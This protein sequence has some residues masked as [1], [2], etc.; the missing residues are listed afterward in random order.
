MPLLDI[1]TPQSSFRNNLYSIGLF[2]RIHH[3]SFISGDSKT[4]RWKYFCNPA[5]VPM[6]CGRLMIKAVATLEP[7][8]SD[9][10]QKLRVNSSGKTL[11]AADSGELTPPVQDEKEL[12]RRNRI[13]KANKGREAWNKGRKHSPETRQ[14]IRERTRL[15]MRSPKVKMKLLKGIH[16]QTRET[17][18]K[19]AAAVRLTWD[20]RRS[21]RRMVARCHREW[22]T[23]ISEAS[24]KG[25]AGEE[26]L[27][28]DSYEIISKQLYK[29]FREGIE[30]RKKR[31]TPGVRAP[32][33]LEQRRKISEAI[34]A[35][36]ADPAYRD[37][38]YSGIAKHRGKDPEPRDPEWGTK[39]KE[40]RKV[41][42]VKSIRVKSQQPRSKTSSS[43]VQKET[44]PR[45]KD[46]QARYKLEMI[47]SIRAQRA[48]S[49]PKISEAILRANILI[50]E[51][52]RAAEALEAAAAKSP[53]AEASLVET[54]KLIAEAISYIK[55][56]ETDNSGTPGASFD[57]EE[58]VAGVKDTEQ[59]GVNGVATIGLGAAEFEKFGDLGLEANGTERVDLST[60]SLSSSP[61]TSSSWSDL[62]LPVKKEETNG[63]KQEKGGKGRRWV[64]GR[65]VEDED[66]DECEEL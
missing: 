21:H 16:N 7:M 4:A 49:D 48:A 6:N 14:K 24:R 36:W 55:S 1:A 53:M 42:P 57:K 59:K 66:E 39:R 30:S 60:M 23:L 38:V 62:S 37:R 46:P 18:E 64:C 50:G 28:W 26:E 47:K 58:I 12:L 40:P 34:A 22:L 15:A 5:I 11:P 27:Q 45:F 32:K 44:Q 13:S 20:K 31:S 51:A 9:N 3:V 54:R 43:P 41:K 33:T 35:K 63:E 61:S 17:R 19:I 25:L 10:A 2:Q 52:Q 56:I 29:E 65:L 8:C